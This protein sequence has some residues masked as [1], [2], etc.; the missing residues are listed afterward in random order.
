[1]SIRTEPAPMLPPAWPQRVPQAQANAVALE[2]PNGDGKEVVAEKC[3]SCHDLRRT[4][5]KRS[6]RDHWAHTVNRMRTRMSILSI[7]DLT[8]QETTKIVDYLVSH[9][10]EIQPYDAN[11]R[12]PRT[13]Q[14]GKA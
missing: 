14:T 10:G 7:P 6:N 1:M 11:S 3:T 12:L 9:F 5:V 4:I 13:L 8:E 2:L